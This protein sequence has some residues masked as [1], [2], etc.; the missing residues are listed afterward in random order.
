[1]GVELKGVGLVGNLYLIAGFLYYGENLFEFFEVFKNGY[2]ALCYGED[3]A[4][5]SYG[6]LFN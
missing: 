2:A 4:S 3:Y 1:L 5:F 6:A